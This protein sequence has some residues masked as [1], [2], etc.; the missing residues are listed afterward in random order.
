MATRSP[1]STCRLVGMD[2]AAG[3]R[4]GC[5]EQGWQSFRMA[6]RSPPFGDLKADR[7][8]EAGTPARTGERPEKLQKPALEK[9]MERLKTSIFGVVKCYLN[10]S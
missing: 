5:D 9:R 8:I 7:G 6:L 3:F 2:G 10:N 4:A 1:A